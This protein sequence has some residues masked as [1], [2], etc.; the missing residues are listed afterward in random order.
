LGDGRLLDDCGAVNHDA[1][2]LQEVLQETHGDTQG[3]IAASMFRTLLYDSCWR[4]SNNKACCACNLH[5]TYAHAVWCS[6]QR[7]VIILHTRLCVQATPVA[8]SWGQ[9]GVLC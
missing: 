4:V 9:A 7:Y 2:C 5:V 1:T 6:P 3:D 8:E